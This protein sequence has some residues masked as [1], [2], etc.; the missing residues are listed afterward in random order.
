MI[1]A[2]VEGG[3]F[4]LVDANVPTGAWESRTNPEALATRDYMILMPGFAADDQDIIG[5]FW[6]NSA[7]EISR[8]LH[9]DS[10][11]SWA[12]TS[13]AT[14]M[15]GQAISNVG[16]P[17]FAA[18]P[19]LF[20]EY[21]VLIAWTNY[22]TADADLR[23]WTITESAITEKT[24]VVLNSTDDQ[25]YCG[26]GIDDLTRYWYAFYCGK[27]D[28]SETY[29]TALNTYCKISQDEGSTWSAEFLVSD[30]NAILPATSF[31]ALLSCPIFRQQRNFGPILCRDTTNIEVTARC[32]VT[33]GSPRSLP[34]VIG[35]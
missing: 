21:V 12:E 20:E 23:C 10:G 6:D 35:G 32:V 5:I 33:L 26:L 31:S 3:F 19:D 22:D 34:Q 2:G 8:Y 7:S 15:T 13:I 24:E 1:D 29:R 4:R 9:D 16:Q 28:G 18:F 25:A 11:N 17:Q 14:G 27:S 30:P